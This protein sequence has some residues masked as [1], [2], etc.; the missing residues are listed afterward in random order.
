MAQF[1]ILDF[2]FVALGVLCAAFGG[3][4]FI[5]G[6]VAITGRLRIP[7]SIAGVTVAAFAT[8]SPELSV[9]VNAAL[10]GTPAIALGD[11]LGSN[12]A[13]IG[14]IL[15]IALVISGIHVPRE[16]IRRDYA[17]A[18]AVPF[19]LT[20]LMIDGQLG[21]LDG[22]ILLATFFGW[23]TIVV[24]QALRF[25][26]QI[27][28]SVSRHS[29]PTL[30]AFVLGGLVLL[31][32]AGR[33]IVTGASGLAVALGLPPFIIGAVVVAIGTS[34]PELATTLMAKLRGH[35]EIGLGNILGSNIFNALWIVGI[36]AIISPI[37]IQ[38]SQLGVAL[39]FGFLVTA[40]CY[41]FGD[42]F[43]GRKRGLVLLGVYLIYT[44]VIILTGAGH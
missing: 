8:S 13:N 43:L 16:T 35:D 15:G 28:I 42:G 38:I 25:R 10:A 19:L 32:A 6:T 30:A 24:T 5:K 18:L 1:Q 14:L 34:T 22:A 17:V 33:L 2:A 9:A 7:A 29:A 11:S 3:D 12:V 31:V 41:P 4:A 27:E 44:A 26:D 37:S 23:L 21:R 39:A 20:L 36:I 40:I